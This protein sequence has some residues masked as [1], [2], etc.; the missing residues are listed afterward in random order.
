[1]PEHYCNS[2][3][4]SFSTK[5]SLYRHIDNQHFTNKRE[6]DTVQKEM[7][8]DSE[9]KDIPESDHDSDSQ[10]GDGPDKSES[11]HGSDS[12]SG[13]ESDNTES[14]SGSDD[15]SDSSD[16]EVSSEESSEENAPVTQKLVDET[17]GLYEKD[18]DELVEKFTTD[19]HSEKE[20]RQMAH[21]E[22]VSKYRKS[23]RKRLEG[24]MTRY[25]QFRR[26]P[27]Y[28]TINVSRKRLREDDDLD[29]N[30]SIK[31]AIRHRKY[32]IYDQ[33]PSDIDESD[34]E[35]SSEQD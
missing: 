6:R 24:F 2:C 14:E 32:R 33:F 9:Q 11:D 16:S 19:G 28:R 31:A 17:Y 27:L 29:E 4:K 8:S 15:D 5:F 35:A 23:F 13:D 21:Q 26:E 30:E 34:E 22:L 3:H 10:G 12:R 20:A 1:M 25:E 18:F 7:D